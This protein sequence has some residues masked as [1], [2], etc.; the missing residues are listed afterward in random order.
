M[1]KKFE[2]T[3]HSEKNFCTYNLPTRKDFGPTKYPLSHNG[4]MT[5]DPWDSRDPQW[6]AS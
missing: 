1:R 3:K 2:P 4:N 6:Y 5:R